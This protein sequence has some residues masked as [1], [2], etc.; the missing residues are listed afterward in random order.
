MTFPPYPLTNFE[1]Q[2]YYQNEPKFNG[3]FSR[4]NLPNIIKNDAYVI[5]LDEYHDIGTHW[6]ALYVQ[7]TSVY[8]TY[9]NNKIV[10]YFDSFG[11]E[12]IPKEIMNFINRKKIITNIYRIQA[13]DSIM[14]G[15]FCIGFINFM[16]NSL[17]GLIGKSLTDYTNLLSPN[18][19]NKNDDIYM[20]FDGLYDVK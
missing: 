15:Y 9:V 12:H 3:V 18:D 2:E 1:I 7:S 16:F 8:N 19:F 11:V 14:C 13:Y 17:K 5:N 6:V 20:M 4:D 10:T